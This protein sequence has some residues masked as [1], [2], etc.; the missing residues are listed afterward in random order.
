MG[1]QWKQFTVYRCAS[2]NFAVIIIMIMNLP[3]SIT[4]LFSSNVTV[5]TFCNSFTYREPFLSFFGFLGWGETE[6]T[7]YTGNWPAYCNVPAPDDRRWVWSSRWN[8]NREGKPKYSEKTC[9]SATLSTTNSHNLTWHRTRAAATGSWRLTARAMAVP[10]RLCL[11]KLFWQRDAR[12][13]TSIRGWRNMQK[14]LRL[15]KNRARA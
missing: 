5:A 13:A 1:C 8:E 10:Y 4:M 3:S 11:S 7:W 6:S 9:L 14:S 12:D 15:Q 2:L